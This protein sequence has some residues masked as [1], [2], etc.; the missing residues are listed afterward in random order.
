M[1]VNDHSKEMSTILQ[2]HSQSIFPLIWNA[3]QQS[4]VGTTTELAFIGNLTNNLEVFF[5]NY[6]KQFLSSIGIFVTYKSKIIH[7]KPIVK[8]GV[9]KCE[10]G[11]L[12]VVV[13]YH[14]DPNNWEAKSIIYQVK[15]TQKSNNFRCNINQKQ[16]KLLCDWPPFSFGKTLT[17]VP[18]PFDITPKTIEFGSFMLEPRNPPHGR[19]VFGRHNGYYGICPHAKLVRLKLQGARSVDISSFP[20]TRGDAENFFN[21]LL[22]EIG[23]HHSNQK[24]Q[25][26]ID[27]LYRHIEWYT[28][29]PEEFDGYWIKKE[30]D[31]FAVIEIA[32]KAEPVKEH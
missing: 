15:L 23:E 12:L 13:K 11:D 29:P 28:D 7:Q 14:Y 4:I 16:L 17:G 31:G 20:Y 5:N 2:N 25:E 18:Q 30:D 22:F 10:L 32:I 27:A 8:F 1:F 6:L 3:F 26:L 24:V 19:V 9:N 21:H